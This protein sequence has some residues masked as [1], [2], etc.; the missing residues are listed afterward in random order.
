MPRC[1]GTASRL[2]SRIL[3]S[4]GWLVSTALSTRPARRR[5][6]RRADFAAE[7]RTHKALRTAAK[8]TGTRSPSSTTAAGLVR[9]AGTCPRK[10]PALGDRTF[11]APGGGH[12]P[13]L[14]GQRAGPG[15]RTRAAMRPSPWLSPACSPGFLAL[16]VNT[17]GS[18]RP[19]SIYS[20]RAHQRR[21]ADR[22]GHSDP[23]PGPRFMP[24]ASVGKLAAQLVDGGL[25]RCS[26]KSTA[27]QR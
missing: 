27:G 23:C 22:D 9:L 25:S 18:G 13:T 19:G 11:A 8:P 6:W 24:R 16:Q 4:T 2:L 17:G 7:R 3:S 1:S 21:S 26:A 5:G 14:S 12:T 20:V 15:S 10:L